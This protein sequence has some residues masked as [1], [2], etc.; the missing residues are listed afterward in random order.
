MPLELFEY[1]KEAARVLSQ[2]RRFGLHDEMGIGKTASC[3]GAMDAAGVERV[4]IAVAPVMLKD[5][6]V[7]EIERF[8]SV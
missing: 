5:N 2:N 1:Q 7:R 4:V 6:W 8:Q 3:I